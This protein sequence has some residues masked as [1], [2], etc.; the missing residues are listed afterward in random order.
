MNR[1]HERRDALLAP[2]AGAQGGCIYSF[3]EVPLETLEVLFEEG[4]IDP[5]DAQNF[6]PTAGEFLE[7]LR[8]VPTLTVHGYAVSHEREDYR[9]SIEGVAGTVPTLTALD[10]LTDYRADEATTETDLATPDLT[11]IY[12]W[13]D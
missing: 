8:A 2:Y 9:V 13:W 7:M 1:D 12:L 5:E 6:A 10:I 11:N 4:F 3:S